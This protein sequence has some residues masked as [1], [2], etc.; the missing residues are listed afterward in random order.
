MTRALRLLVYVMV[1]IGALTATSAEQTVETPLRRSARIGPADLD[2]T[3]T[4]LAVLPHRPGGARAHRGPGPGVL[5]PP[6]HPH[7]GPRR[8]R[9][10]S[11]STRRSRSSWSGRR[12]RGHR[13]RDRDRR[14]GRGRRADRPSCTGGCT[15]SRRRACSGW[16]RV[17][18]AAR[19]RGRGRA[20][21]RSGLTRAG[22]APIRASSGSSS[23][24]PST[25]AVFG[26]AYA[27]R[28]ARVADPGTAVYRRG[29]GR[30]A[31]PPATVVTAPR[32]T[33]DPAWDAFVEASEPGSYLQLSAWARVKAVNGWRRHRIVA[34]R[35]AATAAHRRADPRPPAPPDAVGVRLCAAR[36]GGRRAGP[37]RRDGLHGAPAGPTCAARPGA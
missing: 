32:P 37:R 34:D 15:S 29:H 28:L 13:P 16:A 23:R 4:T 3:A 18:S 22:S 6:G 12:A 31:P 17:A 26:A 14:L 35:R 33:D 20:T 30:R 25:S 5:R 1:P 10:R 7:A 9:A 19:R 21:A 27:R 36:P 8:G 11:S 2:L 24:S